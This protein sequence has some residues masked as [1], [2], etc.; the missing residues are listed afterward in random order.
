MPWIGIRDAGK[1]HGKVIYE[2]IQTIT[3]EGLAN[4]SAR[5]LPKDTVC[6]SRTASVGYVTIMGLP[7]ATSQDFATWS[8]TEALDPFYLMYALMAEGDNIREFG[9]GTTHTTIYFPEIRAF[10]ICLAPL[11][12]QKEI[13]RRIESAFR[14]IDRISLEV[15]RAN[16]LIGQLDRTLLSLAFRGK[17]VAQN[18]T[19][20]PAQD[21][22]Q[23]FEPGSGTHGIRPK[24][25]KKH[26]KEERISMS[27]SLFEV[28]SQ[29]D[30]WLVA[31]DAFLLCG[32]GKN[33]T[34]QTIEPLYAELRALDQSG[35]LSVEVKRDSEGR[36]VHDRIKLKKQVN[37]AP[38]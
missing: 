36:K 32:V 20:E 4:S 11:A 3:R 34:T 28:L 9:R 18:P 33:A 38:G 6:L 26:I 23:R 8:C 19:D 14:W 37:H 30:D 1:S 16:K 21:L 24:L 10:N 35:Q 5:I 29:A 27:K 13:V 17:L 12:E 31:Q 25:I 15:S 7:M 2:T 22:L